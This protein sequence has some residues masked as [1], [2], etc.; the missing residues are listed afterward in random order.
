MRQT[1]VNLCVLVLTVGATVA[2]IA[3]D[4]PSERI[5]AVSTAAA[6]LYTAW[7]QANS[8]TSPREQDVSR[9]GDGQQ[10]SS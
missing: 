3:L 10:D 8:R 4:L 9:T 7:H 6:A 2:L 1:Y 5:I